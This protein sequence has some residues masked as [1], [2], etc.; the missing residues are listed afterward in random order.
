MK[1]RF[2][3]LLL[4]LLL[5]FTNFGQSSIK[6]SALS[7]A[8]PESVG[9]SSE[10]LTR[11]DNI[12]E[13]A[14]SDGAVPGIVALVA[15]KG[16]VVYKKAFGVANSTN[17]E[18]L[19]TDDIFRI[20]SQTKAVTST[21]VMMLWEEGHFQL[22]DPIHN[23]I[24][25]FKDPMVLQSFTFKD[26][27]FVGVPAKN[28][29]T[30]RHLLTHTSG[31]GYGQIDPDERMQL[32]Y[33]KAGI[34]EIGSLTPLT[35]EENIKNLAKMPLH[36]NPGEKYHYSMGLD[37]LAYFVEV[38]S[39]MRF[40][41]FL[42]Q[43]IF[44]P[45][46]MNDTYFYLP[47]DK[48]D[49]LVTLHV[50]GGKGGT[51]IPLPK[52]GN[53]DPNLPITGSRT[54]HS[55]GGGLSCTIEDYAKFLQMYLNNGTYN[56][57]RLLS[58]TTIQAM[59]GNQIGDL[60]GN[61]GSYYGLAFGVVDDKGQDKGGAGSKGT[62]SWGGAFNTQY[63]ADPEEEI[64]GIIFKQTLGQWKDKTNWQFRQLVGQSVVNSKHSKSLT[65]ANP[66]S[67]G[68]SSDRLAHLDRICEE[69]IADKAIPGAVALVAKDG[70]IVYHKAF[71]KAD[72]T[73]GINMEKDAIFRIASQ[74]KAITATAV[75]MLWEE[76][77]FQLD[78]P[79][80]KWIPEFSEMKILDNYNFEHGTYGS[81]PAQKKITIRHLLTHTSGIGYGVIDQKEG[82]RRLYKEA[83]I[84]EFGTLKSELTTAEN[85][86]R[87]AQMPLHFEPGEKY[88]YGMG[89]DVLVYFV[90][91]VSG[92][93]F[94]A[95]LQERLFGPLGMKDTYFHLPAKKG[96]RLVAVQRPKEDG[97]EY[98]PVTSY[99]PAYPIKG[100]KGFCSGGAGLVSTAKDYATFL[101]MYLNEG[102]LNGT[103]I[104]S[105]TTV[106]SIMGNHIGDFWGN[107]GSH[108]GLAFGVVTQ[109]GQD[110]GGRGSI[111]VS[112][113]HLTLPTI[114]SV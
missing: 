69:A 83:G 43:R 39:G 4:I 79:V 56:G 72:N 111:A 102:Q 62:F 17:S 36:F 12:C 14:I 18:P 35:T 98:M 80:A 84:Q 3:L 30:I 19:K 87:I 88:Q 1:N 68:M 66:E 91:V 48:E 24:P 105:P 92:K 101:Q 74:T 59:M 104:L 64:I 33:S 6:T 47:K 55:G 40:D 28:P 34:C 23:W 10:R 52:Q 37:V 73:Q 32:L 45:L 51:M 71:G 16:K 78:D 100:N 99:D 57:H 2:P 20:A 85:V 107:G 5:P 15:R 11:I 63:F 70:K 77:H 106:K 82:M 8:K 49:R 53:N 97:W 65:V 7:M 60:W 81:H 13:A 41:K 109:K 42:H 96:S 113:T 29:I 67:V 22:D 46:E 61:G 58:R 94:E 38:V 44:E 93:D 86:K 25:E 76:G 9:M 54:I 114:Y 90:E 50:A 112:Y 75:M 95:F 27:S 31:I 26:T 110:Q 21:A 89:L 103:Q 108:Y